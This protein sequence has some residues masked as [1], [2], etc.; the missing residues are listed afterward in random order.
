ME[1]SNISRRV[2]ISVLRHAWLVRQI[3][4]EFRML[5][6]P[7]R[8]QSNAIEA[9]Q[10]AAEASLSA[11]YESK[12]TCPS[13]IT[14]DRLALKLNLYRFGLPRRPWHHPA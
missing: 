9:L 2:V 3:I 11:Y 4:Q 5:D 8:G 1:H 7:F 6:P 13:S 14:N 12:Y 10:E